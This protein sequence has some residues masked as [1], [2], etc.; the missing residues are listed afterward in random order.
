MDTWSYF[1]T[2]FNPFA[3]R[4]AK[5]VYNFG[6]SECNRVK[7]KQSFG[8][9]I[10]IF[11]HHFNPFALRKAKIVCN[12]GLFGCNRVKGRQSFGEWIHIHI[13]PPFLTL[14]YS[15]RPKLNA[16]LAFLSAEG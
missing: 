1:T 8:E 2:I 11:H 7:G 12:F 16:I 14:L 6:L 9:W 13:S 3:L 15:E 4:K 10:H 5:I